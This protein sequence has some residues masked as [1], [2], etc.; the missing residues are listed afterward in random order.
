M[1][2]QP[3]GNEEDARCGFRLSSSPRASEGQALYFGKHNRGAGG[4]MQVGSGNN[5]AA[6]KA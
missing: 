6:H 3:R 4:R 1:L 5:R 2:A